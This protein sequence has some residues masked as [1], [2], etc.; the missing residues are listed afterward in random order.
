[1]I[2]FPHCHEVYIKYII[3]EVAALN[4]L[5]LLLSIATTHSFPPLLHLDFGFEISICFCDLYPL[6]MCHNYSYFETAFKNWI[7]LFEYVY[8]LV[9]Q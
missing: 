4:G 7:Y 9:G 6:S 3:S 1:M 5:Q 2:L 8:M